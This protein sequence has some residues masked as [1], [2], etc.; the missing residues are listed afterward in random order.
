MIYLLLKLFQFG[1]AR[2]SLGDS[3]LVQLVK[4]LPATQK[5]LVR[6]LG[7]EDLLENG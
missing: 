7:Q 1:A 6:F 3:L 5:T 4:N 2:S